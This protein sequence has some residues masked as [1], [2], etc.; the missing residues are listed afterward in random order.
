MPDILICGHSFI[1]RYRQYL[2][3]LSPPGRRNFPVELAL[4]E[5]GNIAVYGQ[6]GLKCD[7]DGRRFI[8]DKVDSVRPHIL[9]LEIGT[10]DLCTPRYSAQEV[11]QK[12]FHFLSWVLNNSSVKVV[13][14]CKVVDRW[15]LR[16]GLSHTDF[17]SK[18]QQF[19]QL[20]HTNAAT[21]LRY[22]IHRHERNSIVN[23]RGGVVSTDNIHVNTNTGLR[24]YN[25]S[26]RSAAVKGLR[27]FHEIYG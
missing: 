3:R 14:L 1:K 5:A 12:L 27:R 10:N 11:A 15:R 26:I 13:V 2:R 18:R 7:Y 19:N 21:D 25:F 23:I 8:M 4:P 20:L 16:D 17:E 6:S 9:V 22:V 24:L